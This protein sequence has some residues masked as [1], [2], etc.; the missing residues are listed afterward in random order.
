MAGLKKITIGEAVSHLASM[1]SDVTGQ[2]FIRYFGD[3]KGALLWNKFSGQCGYSLI[4]LWQLADSD[5][6]GDI[7]GFISQWERK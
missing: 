6:R 7:L 5:T 2:D 1:G 3:V 4:V